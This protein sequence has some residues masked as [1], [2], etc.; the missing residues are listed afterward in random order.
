M[1]KEMIYVQLYQDDYKLKKNVMKRERWRMIMMLDKK[2][3]IYDVV[4]IIL[5][6]FEMTP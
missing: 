3:I 6:I 4:I 1:S 5:I 2:E